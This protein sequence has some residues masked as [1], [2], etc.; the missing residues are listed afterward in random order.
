MRPDIF[1]V[2]KEGSSAPSDH[3]KENGEDLRLQIVLP[4]DGGGT[5]KSTATITMVALTETEQEHVDA[6]IQSLLSSLA[7]WAVSE[8]EGRHDVQK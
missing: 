7:R 2:L 1:S 5:R 6:K 8:K 4:L 3:L